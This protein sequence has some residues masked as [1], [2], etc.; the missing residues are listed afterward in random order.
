MAE[1]LILAPHLGRVTL[2]IAVSSFQPS[3]EEH[4]SIARLKQGHLV[5]LNISSLLGPF[6]SAP[7]TFPTVSV[8]SI[9]SAKT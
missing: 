9:A 2:T 4:S 1:R 7:R 5:L 8:Y 6:R 3:L